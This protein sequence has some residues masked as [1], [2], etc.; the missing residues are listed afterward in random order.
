MIEDSNE[1]KKAPSIKEWELDK[2]FTELK[3]IKIRLRRGNENSKELK[4]L[5]RQ[6][7]FETDWSTLHYWTKPGILKKRDIGKSI[8]NKQFEVENALI[9]AGFDYI[10]WNENLKMQLHRAYPMKNQKKGL[11]KTV[12]RWSNEFNKISFIS[13][14]Q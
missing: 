13:R 11:E 2:I 3:E 9:A 1:K 8:F 7:N 12:W 4:L 14:R 6:P 5:N 10:Y